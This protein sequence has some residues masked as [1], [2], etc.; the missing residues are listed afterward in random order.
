[1]AYW[2]GVAFLG[3]ATVRPTRLC[4]IATA[5]SQPRR[6]K[7]MFDMSRCFDVLGLAFVAQSSTFTR[8]TVARSAHRL[9]ARTSPGPGSVGWAPEVSLQSPGPRGRAGRYRTEAGGKV[10]GRGG[11]G[12]A[13]HCPR[14]I[15]AVVVGRCAAAI[16]LVPLCPRFRCL[17]SSSGGGRWGGRC[18]AARSSIVEPASGQVEHH[19]SP[20]WFSIAGSARRRVES[21]GP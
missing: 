18:G 16:G 2:L 4:V 13:R 15:C 6:C 21:A 20:Q 19:R 17:R 14:L 10:S 8:Y 5:L 7:L 11:G 3:S 1:M 9:Q 12:V